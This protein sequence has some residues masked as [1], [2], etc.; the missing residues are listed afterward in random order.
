MWC[1]QGLKTKC[2]AGTFGSTEGLTTTAC[3]GLCPTGY[4]CPLGSTDYSHFPC[5]DPSTYC[6]SGSS[7]PVGVSAANL[8]HGIL[9]REGC[10]PSVPAWNIRFDN[11]PQLA[12]VFRALCPRLDMSAGINFQPTAA[13]SC[14]TMNGNYVGSYSTNGQ[15]CASCRPGFWCGVG[16][17]SST[18]NKCGGVSSYCPLGSSG[19]STVQVGFYSTNANSNTN[20]DFTTQIQCPVASTALIPQCPS[21]TIGPNSLL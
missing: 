13:V 8:P 1:T 20:A 7:A 9:L 18:Q 19:P 5:L 15:L 2:P 16:S 14:S 12:L 17:S 11:G 6:P 10:S 21:T 3:S 4:Y